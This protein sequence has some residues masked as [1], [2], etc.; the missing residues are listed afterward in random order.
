LENILILNPWTGKIGP[1]T[2]LKGIVVGLLTKEYEVTIV[3]PFS[4]EVSRN[5]ELMGCKI[6]YLPQLKL[7]HINNF[8]LK[9]FYRGFGELNLLYFLKKKIKS[10]DF[11]YCIINTEVLSWSLLGLKNK[12]PI[13]VIVHALSFN[14]NKKLSSFIFNLQ[15][16]KVSKYLAVSNAVK[17]ALQK[18]GVKCE[19][20]M[21]YNGVDLEQ[22]NT[23]IVRVERNDITLLS[24]VHPV[25]NKGAHHLIDVLSLLKIM[26][27]KFRCNIAGW[28]NSSSDRNYIALIN[29]KIIENDLE[30]YICYQ[31]PEIE[32]KAAYL[33]ADILIH[34]SENESF[35]FA[36]AEGMAMGLPVV[37]FN[38]GG[39]PEVVKHNKTGFLLD[40]YNVQAMALSV[41]EL[42]KSIN[43]RLEF[44]KYGQQRVE[45]K[46]DMK[47]NIDTI[48]YEFERYL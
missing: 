9:L 24:V 11:K 5:L 41:A 38:V 45:Q 7:K 32:M 42:M 29:S 36:L 8:F 3:Y 28:Y 27:F 35:G 6:F 1:N 40:P 21:V 43:L 22:Y 44:G 4:D 37:A 18:I 46:F 39:I 31:K 33:G 16:K 23:D 15:R 25:P 17:D 13:Y 30:A 12:T 19:V 14:E 2:F 10:S 20:L 34:P 48:L 26:G 47:K